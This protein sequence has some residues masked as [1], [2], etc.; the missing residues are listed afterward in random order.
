LLSVIALWE[1]PE[2]G[3]CDLGDCLNV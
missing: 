2:G 3:Y 1:R